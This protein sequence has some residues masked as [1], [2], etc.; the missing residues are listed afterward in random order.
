MDIL[1]GSIVVIE[2]RE[3]TGSYQ[4]CTIALCETNDRSIRFV[5]FF[6]SIHYGEKIK[7]TGKLSFEGTA[8]ELFEVQDYRLLPPTTHEHLVS[9]LTDICYV[10]RDVINIVVDTFRDQTIDVLCRAPERLKDIPHFP[11]EHVATITEKW[12]EFNA[13]SEM[14]VIAD[15]M[16]LPNNLI[17]S[18]SN[19]LPKHQDITKLIYKDP[20]IFYRSDILDWDT[21]FEYAKS[22][23]ANLKSLVFLRS[24]LLYV[25]RKAWETGETGLKV[26]NIYQWANFLGLPEMNIHEL[27]PTQKDKLLSD[28]IKF[29]NGRFYLATTL[30]EVQALFNAL[31]GINGTPVNIPIMLEHDVQSTIID[32]C[33][34]IADSLESKGWAYSEGLFSKEFDV[35]LQTL[36]NGVKKAN[37]EILFGAPAN[38]SLESWQKGK[39]FTYEDVFEGNVCEWTP[40]NAIE[41]SLLVL[42]EPFS[43]SLK[44]LTRIIEGCMDTSILMTSTNVSIHPQVVFA[45]SVIGLSESLN[46]RDL[47]G[48]VHEAHIDVTDNPCCIVSN[49]FFEDA[50]KMS[51]AM[52]GSGYKSMVLDGGTFSTQER[53]I[54]IHVPLKR[55]YI[56]R[57]ALSSESRKLKF[58]WAIQSKELF[59]LTEM[60][61]TQAE[62]R[63]IFDLVFPE[64]IEFDKKGA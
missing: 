58:H 46:I 52:T 21:A 11:I 64:E 1:E 28:N 23:N 36:N 38:H 50:Q 55:P 14:D 16:N 59:K 54:S 53:D 29:I 63:S 26:R 12:N 47:D 40:S 5:G 45:L 3:E 7:A 6:R 13:G 49:Q 25:L 19:L 37:L 20:M 39:S 30:D 61:L 24:S 15:K 4:D 10:P 57:L 18:L 43:L 51:R 9:Y 34:E 32:K 41:E 17:L 27:S 2:Y 48:L 62:A 42:A 35:V 31:E 60:S 44:K 56:N 22:I 8:H 33:S